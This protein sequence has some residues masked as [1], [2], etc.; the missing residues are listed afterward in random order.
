[1]DDLA[2]LVDN[3]DKNTPT[4]VACL[5]RDA[6][7]Y[8]PIRDAIAHTALLTDAA[9]NKLTSVYE[10]IKGRVKTMLSGSK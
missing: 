10:N 7:E 2:Y 8:K 1:M 3:K 5:A 4:K 6:D 9:K